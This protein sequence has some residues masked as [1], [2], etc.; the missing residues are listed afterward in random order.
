ME[1]LKRE[2]VLRKVEIQHIEDRGSHDQ[3]IHTQESRSLNNK[4]TIAYSEHAVR[5]IGK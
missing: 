1:L 3:R 2:R 5:T 4:N